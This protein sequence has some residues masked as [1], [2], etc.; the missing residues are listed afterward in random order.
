MISGYWV[1]RCRSLQSTQY[2]L[3]HLGPGEMEDGEAIP[4]CSQIGIV[5]P[6]VCVL[7]VACARVPYMEHCPAIIGVDPIDL[8][9]AAWC[10]PDKIDIQIP[11]FRFG[12]PRGR[13]VWYGTPL[14]P[15]VIAP[16]R[17]KRRRSE[18]A[19]LFRDLL[20]EKKKDTFSAG[21]QWMM[22]VLQAFTAL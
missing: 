19:V 9:A 2:L 18:N 14:S 15:A 11:T 1:D 8:S 4:P 3:Y 21:P 22:Y 13:A 12:S 16:E 10:S 5:T 20:R 6:Y 7:P 17:A